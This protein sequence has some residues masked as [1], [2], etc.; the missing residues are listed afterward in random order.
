MNIIIRIISILVLVSVSYTL[1]AQDTN[2]DS[3]KNVLKSATAD[4]IKID[5]LIQ[6]S[7]YYCY[8]EPEEALEYT[9]KA[10]GIAKILNL[11]EQNFIILRNYGI[12]Y[13]EK[14]QYVTARNYYKQSL[15]IAKQLNDSLKIASSFGNIGNTYMNIGDFEKALEHYIKTLKI[16]E[17]LNNENGI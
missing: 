13:T 9:K 12:I 17:L 10:Y 1:F 11:P 8:S 2:I 6:L 15:N 3:L 5:I 7:N 16:F 4:T 14:G